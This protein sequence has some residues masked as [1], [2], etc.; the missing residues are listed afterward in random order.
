MASDSDDT[1][2]PAALMAALNVQRNARVGF[3]AGLVVTVAIFVFFVVVPGVR[4]SPLYYVGL[5]FVLAVGL[6][7][8][9]TMG[10]TMVS[11]YRLSK[12]L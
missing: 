8:L 6:G 12:E 2:G 3:V 5:A 9:L 1:S 10:L 7:G 4:R 11:A